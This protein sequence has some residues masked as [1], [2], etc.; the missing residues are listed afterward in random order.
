MLVDML[1]SQ[2]LR[3]VQNITLE[4]ETEY[5]ETFGDIQQVI[6]TITTKLLSIHRCHLE[7]GLN[8]N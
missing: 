4:I 6:H 2:S 7:M 8:L 1:S 3:N 5:E